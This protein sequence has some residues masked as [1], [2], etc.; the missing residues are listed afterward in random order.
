MPSWLRQART[1]IRYLDSTGLSRGE[2][3]GAVIT[4]AKGGDRL[5]ASIEFTKQ[6]G[7]S[8]QM[9]RAALIAWLAKLRGKQNRAYLTD[10]ANRRRGSFP[11]TELL[12]NNTF[13][14]GTTGWTGQVCNLS[15]PDRQLVLSLTGDH[16]AGP[17]AYQTGIAVTQYAPLVARCGITLGRGV[18]SAGVLAGSTLIT[19]ANNVSGGLATASFVAD[20][21]T[22]GIYVG[23]LNAPGTYIAGDSIIVPYASLSRCALVDNGPNALLRSD[24]LGSS[25]TATRA[26]VSSEFVSAPDGTT[27]G[28]AI[29][30]D[31][32]ASQSH[33]VVQTAAVSASAGDCSFA[34]ALRAGTRTWAYLFMEEA[35]GG[36]DAR[37]FFDLSGGVKGTTSVSGANWS[38]VRSFMMSLGGGWYYCCVVAR[39]TNAATAIN[40][41]I[42]L[43]TGDGVATYSGNGTSYISAWR[44]TRAASSVPTRLAQTTSAATTGA[45]Q[46]GSAL[47]V[48][49]LPASTAGLL[50]PGDQFEV[51]T[52][53]GS[54]LKIVTAA[55]DSDAA[56]LGYL[57]FEPL[58]RGVPA[59]NAAIIIHEPMGRFIFTGE[60]PE[61]SNEPGIF[62]TA[63]ADFEE[64]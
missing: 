16:S 61:W 37:A 4:A 20:G 3:T 24:E 11:A 6:G 21:A 38:N 40:N 51:I 46:T 43:S 23:L 33:Y 31:A 56:G 42:S 8:T 50:L 29:I 13:A 55:L 28:D 59:D 7:A 1:S 48:K 57:Q 18:T 5:A 54:E 25:W 39:K 41:R 30:E 2:Y 47:Y 63:S 17:A 34:C 53:R 10:S 15:V 19:A 14:N 60:A 9:E 12:T 32:T 26:T 35:T 44:G 49:G 36:H 52:S 58:L 27:T 64:A 45:S 62:T 22:A